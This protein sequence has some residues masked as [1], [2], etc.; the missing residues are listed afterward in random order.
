M[1][2]PSFRKQ[3]SAGAD[4]SNPVEMILMTESAAGNKDPARVV[5]EHIEFVNILLNQGA[6]F[7]EEL[8]VNAMR[9][10]YVDYY[11]AQVSNGGH[12]QFVG[13]S[14]WKPS[15]VR[16]VYEGLEAIG[17]KPYHRIFHDLHQLIESDPER[18]KAIGDACGFGESDPEIAKL[19][20]RFF[21]QDASKIITIANAN[22]L[23]GLPELKVVPDADY[24][25]VMQT[26]LEANPQRSARLEERQL[27]QFEGF[28]TDPVRVAS[29]LL[30]VEARCGPLF[31]VLAGVPG[32]VA[33]DG[34]QDIGWQIQSGAERY[35]VFIFDDMAMLCV[36]PQVGG[37]VGDERHEEVARIPASRIYSAIEAAKNTPIATV[38][39]LICA[40]LAIDETLLDV[41]AFALDDRGD[42]QWGMRTDQRS[43]V[44]IRSGENFG[45]IGAGEQP[46]VAAA[47]SSEEL[48]QAIH[49]KKS[50][51]H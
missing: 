27:Q 50:I 23:C 48:R 33:P 12:G 26:L 28:L 44:I 32:A 25:S 4:W 2:F 49:A 41:F 19:D 24:P 5:F 14:S 15:L 17:V 22:W 13:N 18:A 3:S 40:K 10:Y 39:S 30:C 21:A 47:I 6:F 42:W 29:Q 35:V 38:A 16:Y 20:N 34:R 51:L 7:H 36:R 8:P 11:M 9:S 1:W 31:G 46:G 37:S 45:L 43:G